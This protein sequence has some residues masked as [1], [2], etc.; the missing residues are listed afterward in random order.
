M[1]STVDQVYQMQLKIQTLLII[2]QKKDL[3][4]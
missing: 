4:S 2:S 3:T 1:N